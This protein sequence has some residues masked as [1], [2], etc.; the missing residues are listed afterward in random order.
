[1]KSNIKNTFLSWFFAIILSVIALYFL[2]WL[3]KIAF[4]TLIGVIQYL[5]IPLAIIAVIFYMILKK[6]VFRQ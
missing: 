3:F 5:I 2:G 6:K 4:A 1:M